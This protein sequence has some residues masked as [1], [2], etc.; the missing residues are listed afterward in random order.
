M[1]ETKNMRAIRELFNLRTK[2]FEVK[3]G[4]DGDL[5]NA[6]MKAYEANAVGVKINSLDGTAITGTLSG[7]DLI[8]T[9]GSAFQW[10]N[11]QTL[12]VGAI[13]GT[14]A[15][16]NAITQATSSAAGVVLGVEEAGDTN[17]ITIGTITVAAFN[18]TNVVTESVNGGTATPTSVTTALQNLEGY[19]AFA[20]VSGT[21]EGSFTKVVS[22][23]AAALTFD[24]AAPA[25]ATA[26]I[27]FV[28]DEAAIAAMDLVS[29]G[30]ASAVAKVESATA[31]SVTL[32]SD[33]SINPRIVLVDTGSNAVVVTLPDIR[34][35]DDNQQIFFI[36]LDVE[37]N[38]FTFQSYN[39]AQTLDGTDISSGGTPFATVD[40]NGDYIGIQRDGLVWV[41]IQDGIS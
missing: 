32:T 29:K 13:T 7:S 41:T 20:H 3:D 37:T 36:G 10:I 14:I 23:T 38:A 21:L 9:S 24:E 26:V 39:A 16:G 1:K 8:F 35:V 5:A 12:T 27:L 28:T 15:V 6:F 34:L 33:D 19:W 22:N 17:Y 4:T 18:G 11:T 25:S 31:A 30:S 40:A 2:E